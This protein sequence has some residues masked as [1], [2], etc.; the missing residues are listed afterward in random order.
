MEERTRQNKELWE[1]FYKEQNKFLYYPSEDLVAFFSTYLENDLSGKKVLDIGCGAGRNLLLAGKLGANIYGIDS[2]E[3]AVEESQRFLGQKG[4]DPIIRLGDVNSIPY[5]DNYFDVSVL[6]GIFQ[7]L[8][9]SDQEK[10]KKE[11]ERVSRNESWVVFTLR[12]NHD[13][14]YGIGTEIQKDVFVQNKPG[15]K[16]IAI[17]Y[18]TEDSARKFFNLR[19]L[20]IGER[21]KAPIGRLEIKSAHWMIAGRINKNE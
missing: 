9:N 16:R 6:W 10:A 11:I 18:W 20:L 7:Y 8:S 4:F 12:S 1:R 2:S 5:Q 13:S 21:I 19:D 14:R 17:Q 3:R 15:R